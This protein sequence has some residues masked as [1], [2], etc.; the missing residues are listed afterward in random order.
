MKGVTSLA[1]E[2]PAQERPGSAGS[3]GGNSGYNSSED[4][5]TPS[6]LYSIT[7]PTNINME[8][9]SEND[10]EIDSGS[11]TNN[12]DKSFRNPDTDTV[13]S[14]IK[15]MK[16]YIKLYNKNRKS[17]ILLHNNCH[18]FITDIKNTNTRDDALKNLVS[19]PANKRSVDGNLYYK[20][21]Y[22]D[23]CQ[24][25]TGGKTLLNSDICELPVP[26]N[27]PSNYVYKPKE[28]R[29]DK[30]C[31]V[32]NEKEPRDSWAK[33]PGMVDDHT[34]LIKMIGKKDSVIE[35]FKLHKESLKCIK[36]KK[37]PFFFY[38]EPFEYDETNIDKIITSSDAST[39]DNVI[40]ITGYEPTMTSRR[41]FYIIRNKPLLFN[42]H[43]Q[44]GW[45]NEQITKRDFL[46]FR[47]LTKGFWEEPMQRTAEP[48]HVQ[49]VKFLYETLPRGYEDPSKT[50]TTH[51][52]QFKPKGTFYEVDQ[53]MDENGLFY[54]PKLY[55]KVKVEQK[56]IFPVLYDPLP[57]GQLYGWPKGTGEYAKKTGEHFFVRVKESELY[58]NEKIPLLIN[59]FDR[60][61]KQNYECSLCSPEKKTAFDVRAKD[62]VFD[63]ENTFK[64]MNP[65]TGKIE[66]SNAGAGAG[67]GA[68]D[69]AGAG[70]GAGAGDDAGAGASTAVKGG[71]IKY[72][73][74]RKLNSKS[75]RKLN[76]KSRRKLNSKSRRK[77]NSKSRRN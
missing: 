47:K 1:E 18:K 15:M 64:F 28:L 61:N 6:E 13:L 40:F 16:D 59:V 52:G 2:I 48:F 51:S 58:T 9:N 38:P 55:E 66:T 22:Y 70:A 35:S 69:G 8:N 30:V 41:E 11:V 63:I 57:S 3:A 54:N 20:I 12:I 32:L 31:Q 7:K 67:A 77:L 25:F 71:F 46:I 23:Y 76:S 21:I 19:P 72:K 74:K 39:P 65:N 75:R 50:R 17:G 10:S 49:V 34:S 56:G 29:F 24:Q 68:G 44:D 5:R 73:S 4:E 62:A 45:R 53:Y 14:K 27:V 26:Q 42:F 43:T 36:C 60:V 33:L 37:P